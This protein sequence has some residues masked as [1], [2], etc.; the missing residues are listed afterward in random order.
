MSVLIPRLTACNFV[1]EQVGQRQKDG[2]PIRASIPLHALQ[3]SAYVFPLHM[4][5]HTLF[6]KNHCHDNERIKFECP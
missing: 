4:I 6:I 5:L 3:N 1:A 2:N